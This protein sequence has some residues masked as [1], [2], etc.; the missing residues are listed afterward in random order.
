M[1]I[2]NGLQ[3]VPFHQTIMIIRFFWFYHHY[4]PDVLLEMWVRERPLSLRQALLGIIIWRWRYISSHSWRSDLRH[5]I[6]VFGKV[7]QNQLLDRIQTTK[8]SIISPTHYDN[9]PSS[10]KKLQLEWVIHIQYI[11][12]TELIF[13]SFWT[14]LGFSFTLLFACSSW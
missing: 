9:I 13:S 10:W 12:L 14:I 4:Y 8:T 6:K 11:R 1:Y 2:P 3:T 7:T 5:M